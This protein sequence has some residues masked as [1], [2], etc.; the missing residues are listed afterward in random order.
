MM[1]YEAVT[2]KDIAKALGISTSTV[3]R[4][5]R[6]SYEIS[7]ETKALVLE[8]AEKLNYKPNPAALSLKER[9]T[10]SIGVI[11]CEIANN[12]FSQTIDGIESIAYDKGYNIIITQSHESFDREVAILNFLA[13]RS[14]DGLLVSVST[15]TNDI[16]HFKEL[17][18]RGLPIVF[19]DRVVDEI[20]THKVTLDN[21]KG[22]YEA[23]E[24]LIQNGC[25]RIAAI[26]NSEFLLITHERLAGYKE[27]LANNGM[28]VD[29]SLIK[30][31]FYGGIEA[32][33][34]EEAVNQLLTLR[35]RPDAIL[36]TSDKLTTGC[37]SALSRRRIKI[38]DEIALIGFTNS[39]VSELMQTPLSVIKQPANEMGRQAAELLL[40]IVESKRPIKDFEKRVLT[41]EI[42]IRESS[43]KI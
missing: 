39:N 15:E 26:V 9:R 4:A 5:L 10:R 33:E 40:Q 14:V 17:H 13:S 41:P 23:T 16:S 12:F 37:M 2:I 31:C 34:V 6:D 22:T 24:H 28:E 32:Q 3:S 36:C 29:N 8:C 38:P 1:K 43:V 20:N 21:F 42:I 11:V 19:F 30:H 18:D 35:P 25:K 27:A 7:P